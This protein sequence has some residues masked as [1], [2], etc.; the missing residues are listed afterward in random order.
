M[1][2]VLTDRIMDRLRNQK[3]CQMPPIPVRDSVDWPVLVLAKRDHLHGNVVNQYLCLSRGESKKFKIFT[4][5]D[6][7]LCES[8]T[9]V[10]PVEFDSASD[11]FL[12]VFLIESFWRLQV[13]VHLIERWLRK[14]FV[15]ES[16]FFDHAGAAT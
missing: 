2:S 1:L 13:D 3:A 16:S 10:A 15:V 6:A 7:T 11:L 5:D 4:S 12:N 8:A 14:D 9:E